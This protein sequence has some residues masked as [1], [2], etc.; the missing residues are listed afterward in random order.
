[1]TD[2]KFKPMRGYITLIKDWNL[3]GVIKKKGLKMEVDPQRE[4]WLMDN[5]YIEDTRIAKKLTKT[6]KKK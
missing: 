1:M 4:R 6:N 2:I 3:N 5:G